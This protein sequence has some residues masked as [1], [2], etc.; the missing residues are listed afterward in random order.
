M[1]YRTYQMSRQQRLAS[2]WTAEKADGCGALIG[3]LLNGP[4]AIPFQLS[5]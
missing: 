2:E 3:A 4:Q 5:I 1:R